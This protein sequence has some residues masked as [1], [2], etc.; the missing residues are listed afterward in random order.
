MDN[1]IVAIKDLAY[2]TENAAKNYNLALIYD[3]IGQTASAINYYMRAAERTQHKELGY[4]CLIKLALCYERQGNRKHTISVVLKHAIA[5]LPKRPEAY[6]ILS[7]L[8]ER[9][10]DFV[11]AYTFAQVALEVCDFNSPSLRTYVEYPGKW[12]LI[13]EKAV[14]A[15]WWGKSGES[16]D[17]FRNLM[18]NYWSELDEGHKN[19]VLGNIKFLGIEAEIPNFNWGVNDN[20]FINTVN[21]EIFNDR[22]YERYYTVQKNDVVLD[23]GASAGPFT[24][25]IIDK[26]PKQVYCFEPSPNFFKTLSGNFENNP[27]VTCINKAIVS[28]TYNGE[29]INVFWEN[30]ETEF[31]TITF[32]EFLASH[33]VSK[34]DMMK[35]DCEGGE[36]DIFTED[37]LE[38]I[39][40]NIKNIAGEFHFINNADHLN[41]KFKKFRDTILPKLPNY[42]VFSITNGRKNEE[43]TDRIFDDEYIGSNF[44]EIMIYV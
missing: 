12:G 38:F 5:S 13:F 17:L 10:G 30:G 25:S 35:T 6:F 37:N 24:Q 21:N 34:I 11:D 40:N 44:N 8:Y 14:T 18:K 22:I 41:Y 29:K 2:D 33:N 43:L 32:K 27:L 1:L 36:Y 23:V 9:G 26:E 31:P 20:Y 15:W 28:E 7:R 4:E 16:K 19:A 3:S 39:L 42:R